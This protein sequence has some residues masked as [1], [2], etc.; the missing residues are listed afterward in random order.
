MKRY[1]DDTAD[2]LFESVLHPAE[3]TV[4]VLLVQVAPVG[5]PAFAPELLDHR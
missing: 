3:F 5:D 4:G 2:R 1:V